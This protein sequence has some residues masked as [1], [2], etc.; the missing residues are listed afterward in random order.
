MLTEVTTTKAQENT[1]T[2][3]DM[4]L[5]STTIWMGMEYLIALLIMTIKQGKEVEHLRLQMQK[6][7]NLLQQN[8]QSTT[9][10]QKHRKFLS[11]SFQSGFTIV[12]PDA[13][14]LF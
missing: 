2:T 14:L 4:K 10:S 13:L 8:L 11:R 5:I 1:T 7:I 6:A 3:T 12:L 9:Q